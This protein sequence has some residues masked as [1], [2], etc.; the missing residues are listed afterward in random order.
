MLLDTETEVTSVREVDLSQ[1][2]VLDLESSFKNFVS[3]V[4]SDGDVHGH[5]LVSLDTEGS[6]GESGSGWDGFLSSEIFEDLG[7]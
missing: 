6:D 1:F 3:L 5:F 7:C 2:S 4:S